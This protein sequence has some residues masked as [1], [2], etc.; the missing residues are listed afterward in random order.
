MKK[1]I[2][3]LLLFAL[4]IC[5]VSFPDSVSAASSSEMNMLH[6]EGNKIVTESGEQLTLRGT[7]LGSWLMQE[8]WISPLGAGELDHS[9]I[10]NIES[11]CQNGINN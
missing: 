4:C 11:N 3:N 1:L 8:G 9:F 2:C 7:N 5:Y 6:T 10:S